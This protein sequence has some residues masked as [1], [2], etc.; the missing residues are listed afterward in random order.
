VHRALDDESNGLHCALERAAENAS[1][2]TD[3]LE[4]VGL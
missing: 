1:A 3:A 4:D 2:D